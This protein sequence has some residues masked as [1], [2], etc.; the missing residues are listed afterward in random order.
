MNETAQILVVTVITILTVILSLVGIQIVYV[1]SE[2]R[3]ALQKV[4]QILGEGQNLTSRLSHSADSFSGMLTGLK[5]ALSILGV[6]KRERS[7]KDE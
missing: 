7:E 3:Q 6:L 4:N 5:T 2:L 1:L